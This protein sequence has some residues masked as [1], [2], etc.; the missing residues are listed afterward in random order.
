MVQ[1]FQLH[2]HTAG[3]VGYNEVGVDENRVV[4]GNYHFFLQLQ[5]LHYVGW[6]VP[7]LKTY[8]RY[9]ILSGI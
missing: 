3:S 5:S 6:N 2:S 7:P 9:L 1:Q 4:T 8:L